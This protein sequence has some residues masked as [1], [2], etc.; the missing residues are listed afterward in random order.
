MKQFSDDATKLGGGHKTR[1]EISQS[2]CPL[3]ARVVQE[4][5]KRLGSPTPRDHGGLERAASRAATTG[6]FTSTPAK[7]K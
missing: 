5:E 4:I 7:P 2:E 6:T 3:K 1:A